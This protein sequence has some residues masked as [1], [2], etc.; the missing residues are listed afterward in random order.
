MVLAFSRRF[1]P[2]ISKF[3][4]RYF[5]KSDLEQ[6]PWELQSGSVELEKLFKCCKISI[7]Y[8]DF[9]QEKEF[10]AQVRTRRH[11]GRRS[12]ELSAPWAASEPG[13]IFFTKPNPL[14]LIHH[15]RH[16]FTPATKPLL[17][18][19]IFAII[20]DVLGILRPFWVQVWVLTF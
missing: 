13:M 2:I 7:H 17:F 8:D 18:D 10:P 6:F 19:S 1:W 11:W 14:S 5:N 4:H 20:L 16:L 3:Y 15:G 9:T 12:S